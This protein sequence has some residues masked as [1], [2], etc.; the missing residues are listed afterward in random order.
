MTGYNVDDAT[1]LRTEI[2]FTDDELVVIG[3]HMQLGEPIPLS[4]NE[5]KRAMALSD[6]SAVPSNVIPG[7][8]ARAF[9]I[10]VQEGRDSATPEKTP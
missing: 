8:A 4:Y 10:S 5:F 7:P 2:R 1:I 3:G 6:A 9:L